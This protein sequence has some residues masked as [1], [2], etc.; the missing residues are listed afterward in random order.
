MLRE[1]VLLGMQMTMFRETCRV[2]VLG[3]MK[4]RYLLE[5]S[6]HNDKNTRRLASES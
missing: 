6:V 2:F 3:E 5:T 4:S 1:V